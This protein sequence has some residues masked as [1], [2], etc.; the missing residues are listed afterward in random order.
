MK[1][2]AARDILGGR[3]RVRPVRR[4]DEARYLRYRL[5]N[6][7]VFRPF[8]PRHPPG[9]YSVEQMHTFMEEVLL[10][11]ETDRRYGFVITDD[12]EI[13]GHVNLN[14]VVRG[15]FQNAHI[16][17]ATAARHWGRGIMT[18]AVSAVVEAAFSELDLHRIEAAVLPDNAP[19]IAII[20]R[21]DFQEVG[22]ARSYLAIDGVWRDHR[23]FART[24]PGRLVP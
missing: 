2:A 19:S 24:H 11:G 9:Y 5:E 15:A 17:Y 18:A 4:E 10:D 20:R 6:E 16:G 22:L 14:N 8:E 3:Y 23:I 1:R 7:D 13:I 21:N 12:Q